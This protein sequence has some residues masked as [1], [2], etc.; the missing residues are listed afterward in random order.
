MQNSLCISLR[1]T[2]IFLPDYQQSSAKFRS[3]YTTPLKTAASK[4]DPPFD[5]LQIIRY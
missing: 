4:P 2:V 1:R 3:Q 5:S